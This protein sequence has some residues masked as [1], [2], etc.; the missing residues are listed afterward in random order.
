MLKAKENV[1]T[2]KKYFIRYYQLNAV[3]KILGLA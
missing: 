3:H 1:K 2:E